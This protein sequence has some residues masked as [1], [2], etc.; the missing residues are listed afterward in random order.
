MGALFGVPMGF[1]AFITA[2]GFRILRTLPSK[3]FYGFALILKGRAL[4]LSSDADGRPV[5][6]AEIG[7][8]GY[9]G[10]QL[11]GGGSTENIG[12]TAAEDLKIMVFD[13]RVI[14]ELLN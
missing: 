13:N 9:F 4:L 1:C 7:P 11:T 14:D 6:I 8:G 10:D 3:R 2:L 12:I 5:E